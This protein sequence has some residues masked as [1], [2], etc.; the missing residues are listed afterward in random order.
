MKKHHYQFNTSNLVEVSHREFNRILTPIRQLLECNMETT[1]LWE[2]YEA[3]D[4]ATFFHPLWEDE[5]VADIVS[6]ED[7]GLRIP[8]DP[9][10]K[11]YVNKQYASVILALTQ[12]KDN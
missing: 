1:G 5:P 10:K 8:K 11:F 3:W 7:C 9:Y 6:Y 12:K 4:Y 2:G